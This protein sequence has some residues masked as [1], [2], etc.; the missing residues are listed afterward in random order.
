MTFDSLDQPLMFLCL[1]NWMLSFR[2]ELCFIR[3][4]KFALNVYYCSCFYKN[5]EAKHVFYFFPN[6][7]PIFSR[8]L[9]Q[10]SQDDSSPSL[11]F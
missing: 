8:A 9:F 1:W 6:F 11:T 2:H 4:L 10:F 3:Y 7:A 5:E